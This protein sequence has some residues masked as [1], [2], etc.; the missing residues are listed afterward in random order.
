VPAPEAYI[1]WIN[2]H[3]GFNPRSQANSNALSEFVVADLRRLCPPLR[4]ALQSE[5]LRTSRNAKVWTK[6]ACRNIDL[7]F[8]EGDSATKI[9]VEHKSIMAAHG[10]AR[11]NRYGDIIAYCNHMHNHMREAIAAATVVVNCSGAYE[12]PDAFA[13]GL[14]RP[15][16]DMQKVVA[17]TV[18]IFANL[19][20]RQ[21]SDEPNDQPEAVLVIVVD[22]DG[23]NAAKL[24]TGEL[25]PQ[26]GSQ[27]HYD[28]FIARIC[29]LYRER[30][31]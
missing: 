21:L 6:V 2:A 8:N 3:L 20:L 31:T 23:R 24:V 30:F 13:R 11:W 29:E 4:R 27:V 14:P 22:Y 12:N 19:P 28:S 25:S 15:R 7:V 5:Q 17:D 26:P 18:R 1:D 9:A 16:F 10:K